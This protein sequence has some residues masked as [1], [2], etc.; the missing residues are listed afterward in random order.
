MKYNDTIHDIRNHL[1]TIS[2]N[3]ELGKLT[4]E[5]QANS[6]KMVRILNVILNECQQCSHRLTDLKADIAGAQGPRHASLDK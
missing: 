5:Q 3:A 2:M 4:A 6:E 1:N